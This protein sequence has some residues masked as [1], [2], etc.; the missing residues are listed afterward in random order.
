LVKLIISKFSVVALVFI[1][2]VSSDPHFF[3]PIPPYGN[4]NGHCGKRPLAKIKITTPIAKAF[5]KGIKS[6]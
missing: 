3:G 1:F 4:P 5:S 6:K 2:S